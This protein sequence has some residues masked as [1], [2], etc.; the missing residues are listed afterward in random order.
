MKTRIHVN[1]HNIRSGNGPVITVKDYKANRK[2]NE[3]NICLPDGTVVAQ[4]VYRPD[5]PLPCGARCW[6]ET[7]LEVR[8]NE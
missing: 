2:G 6:V 7:N 5:N 3:A 4:I 8:V 1:Q